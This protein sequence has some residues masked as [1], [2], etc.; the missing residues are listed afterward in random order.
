MTDAFT[1]LV[2][3]QLKLEVVKEFRFHPKRLWR[4][5]YCIPSIMCAIEVEGGAWSKGRHTRGKGFIGD[6]EK[7]N[8]ATSLGWRLIRVT[9][10]DLMSM[11]TIEFIKQISN[12]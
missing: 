11:K 8:T 6:M 7:Y 10:S 9:P 5:D 1:Q 2:K 3:S 4:F 12:L